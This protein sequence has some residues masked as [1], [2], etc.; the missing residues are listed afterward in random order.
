[1]L[2]L[3]PLYVWN[4]GVLEVI[5]IAGPTAAVGTPTS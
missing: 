3:I 2:M 5:L 1:M 4:V